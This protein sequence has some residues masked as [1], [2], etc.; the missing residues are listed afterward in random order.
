MLSAALQGEQPRLIRRDFSWK[1]I[2]GD[3]CLLCE[4]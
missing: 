1:E 3:S 4:V 2:I